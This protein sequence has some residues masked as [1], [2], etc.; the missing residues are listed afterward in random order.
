MKLQ[1]RIF[2][3]YLVVNNDSWNRIPVFRQPFFLSK[4]VTSPLLWACD[5][6][7]YDIVKHMV[8]HN[9]ISQY[10]GDKAMRKALYA[11]HFDI[12]DLLHQKGIALPPPHEIQIITR[13]TSHDD[14][15]YK[16]AHD[17]LKCLIVFKKMSPCVHDDTCCS[18]DAKR[19]NRHQVYKDQ[20]VK[21]WG[22]RQLR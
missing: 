2:D 21:E 11:Y 15:L 9:T 13:N 19:W 18:W 3:E 1:H 8:L 17:L 5:M 20:F 12:I 6:G 14:S 4:F 10:D 22:L 7:Y 16:K